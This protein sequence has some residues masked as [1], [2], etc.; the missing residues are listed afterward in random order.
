KDL[1]KLF[2]QKNLGNNIIKLSFEFY[3]N[4][5]DG[6]FISGLRTAQGKAL[7]NFWYN[8]DDRSLRGSI[9]NGIAFSSGESLGSSKS[10]N[11][12][13]PDKSWITLELFI[14]YTT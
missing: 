12:I 7:C 6:T 14:D 4:S 5:S 9:P 1:D 3:T 11:L 13:L 10:N 8:A 2:N